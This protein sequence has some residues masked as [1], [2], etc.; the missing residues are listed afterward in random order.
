VHSRSR[1]DRLREQLKAID[2]GYRRQAID[3]AQGHA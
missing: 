1:I 3:Y 2:L